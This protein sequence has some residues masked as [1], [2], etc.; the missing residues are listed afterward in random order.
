MPLRLCSAH[1]RFRHVTLN[2]RRTVARARRPR[3]RLAR[4]PA[5]GPGRSASPAP[6][7]QTPWPACQPMLAPPALS[8]SGLISVVDL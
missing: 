4:A 5:A 2:P 8:R 7:P 6:V 1:G 3:L